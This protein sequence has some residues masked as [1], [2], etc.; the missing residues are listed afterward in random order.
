MSLRGG[1]RQG[2]LVFSELGTPICFCLKGLKRVIVKT[3]D[4]VGI[5][6]MHLDRLLWRDKSCPA[7]S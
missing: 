7:R 3:A 2:G 5:T 4:S 1:R 6:K